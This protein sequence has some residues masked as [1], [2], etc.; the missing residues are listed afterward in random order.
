V[1]GKEGVFP[2]SF[3]EMIQIP[4]TK[5]ERKKLLKRY[6]Q[7]RLGEA[8]TAGK[9]IVHKASQRAAHQAVAC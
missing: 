9:E 7:G 1:D 3:V 2:A 4:K 5:D 6:Q 8:N